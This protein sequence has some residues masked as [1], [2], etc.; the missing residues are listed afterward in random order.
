MIVELIGASGAGKT[1]LAGLVAS[2]SRSE[3]GSPRLVRDLIVDRPGRRWVRDPRV[4]NLLA[5]ITCLPHVVRRWDRD[6]D[7]IRYAAH[8]LRGNQPSRLVRYNYLREIV[9]DI[10]KHELARRSADDGATVL[11]DEGALLTAYHLLVYGTGSFGP[12]E[13]ERFLGLAPLPDRVVYVTAPLE[14]LVD[15]SR[16]RT[17]R[18][19]ELAS[20]DR[21]EIEGL[22]RRAVEMFDLMV[23]APAIRDRVLVVDNGAD[24]P[25]G[26]RAAAARI[27]AFIGTPRPH[28][29]V[30]AA[31]RSG[32]SS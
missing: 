19:R 30:P 14:V 7:F 29:T 15:R 31:R 24:A 32:G 1:T 8:R 12:A 13:V 5:D 11:V 21:D 16:R 23:A 17:D 10:G 3:G 28:R 9:R 22:L 4:V 18:R 25:S 6:R 20:P 27:A 26:S 2:G